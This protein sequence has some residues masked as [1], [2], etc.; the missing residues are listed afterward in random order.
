ME[1]KR[2]K[3]R[4]A[5]G[6][7]CIA[8]AMGL[9]A[10]NWR[11]ESLGAAH[12]RQAETILVNDVIPEFIS[13]EGYTS[14]ATQMQT[15]EIDGKEYIGV[16]SIPSLDLSLP[17]L[18]K[19]SDKLLKQAPCRYE[20][21]F[22]DDSM[23]IAGHNYRK[24]FSGIKNLTQGD[25]ITFTDVNGAIYQYRVEDMEKIHGTDI[26]GMEA[27]DWDLTLFTCTYG[28]RDRVAV[29]CNREIH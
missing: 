25:S 8:Q 13:E 28:G 4:I 9:T 21:S 6:L 20:G 23:I 18:Y 15:V 12:A 14:T 16:L 27:G 26:E 7:L 3:I 29:R 19:C 17:I 5:L 22:L 10:F 24:H 11:E 2:G 1:N